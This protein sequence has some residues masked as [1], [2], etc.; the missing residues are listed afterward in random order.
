MSTPSSGECSAISRTLTIDHID[1]FPTLIWQS[2]LSGLAPI[3]PGWIDALA[4]QPDGGVLDRPAF[5]ELHAALRACC[6]HVFGQM[7]QQGR[8]FRL[9]SRAALHVR[10]DF[11]FPH[12]NPGVLL[13]GIFYLQVPEGSGSLVFR[14]PRPSLQ[15][16]PFKGGGANAHADLRLTPEAGLAVLFPNWLEHHAEPHGGGAARIAIHFNAV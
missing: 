12:L 8:G 2:R 6:Q 16:S 4:R 13:S 1:L 14:D 11:D 5:A 7:G 10:G 3:F 15:H 9:E